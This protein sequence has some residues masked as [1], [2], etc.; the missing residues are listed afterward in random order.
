MLLLDC[1]SSSGRERCVTTSHIQ[2]AKRFLNLIER[3]G[4]D[5]ITERRKIQYLLACSDLHYRICNYPI[6][7]YYAEEAL[8]KA[9]EFGFV[10]E[11]LPARN[12]LS[13]LCQMLVPNVL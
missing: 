2:E 1:G 10:L 11:V 6:A 9:K 12:R 3:R 5:E 8:K 7:I 13:H 4:L